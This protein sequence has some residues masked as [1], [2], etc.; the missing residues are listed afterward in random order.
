MP[1]LK[2]SSRDETAYSFKKSILPVST[3]TFESLVPVYSE[4]EDLRT[5]Y[6]EKMLWM[7]WRHLPNWQSGAGGKFIFKWACGTLSIEGSAIL[8]IVT[9]GSLRKSSWDFH[10]QQ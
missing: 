1:K 5:K 3:S 8:V 6:Y 2:T 7:L 10:G 4:N 9:A